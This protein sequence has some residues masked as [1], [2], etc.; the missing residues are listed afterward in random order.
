MRKTYSRKAV[1]NIKRIHDP[2]KQRIKR[3]IEDLPDGDVKK[4]KGH[5]N[6]YRLRIGDWRII[7][8]YADKNVILVEEVETRG[9]IY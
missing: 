6:L 7:F 4:L 9:D 8:S 5:D 3:G 1:K 2:D